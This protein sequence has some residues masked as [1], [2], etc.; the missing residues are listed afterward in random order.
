MDLRHAAAWCVVLVIF[1]VLGEAT[2][3]VSGGTALL[4]I[5]QV[6]WRLR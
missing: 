5:I 3:H 1:A 4:G 6:S 2:Q